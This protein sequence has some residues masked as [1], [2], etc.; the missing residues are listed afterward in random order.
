MKTKVNIK[1]LAFLLGGGILFAAGVHFL[2]GFQERRNA[3]ALLKQAERAESDGQND[4]AVKHL[5]TYLGFVPDD[6][7]VLARYGLLLERLA[8]SP[9]GRSQAFLVLEQVLR[10][11][12][13]RNDIRQKLIEIAMHPQV[14]R[15]SDAREHL[16]LLLR[17]LAGEDA[18]LEHR[19]AR[20]H[21]AAGDFPQAAQWY[22]KAIQ[23][24]PQQTEAYLQLAHVYR[25]RLDKA[26]RAD[27]VMDQLVAANA[28]SF[29]A[30]L[31]RGRYYL[32]LGQGEKA[33]ADIGR[34]AELAPD[35]AAVIL[36]AASM[37]FSKGDLATARSRLERG[38]KINPDK[39]EFY[40]ALS[41][42]E[43]KAKRPTEALS[44][45]RRGTEAIPADT[46][47]LWSLANLLIQQGKEPTEEL[48]RLAQRGVPDAQQDF[49]KARL[50]INQR[51][52]LQACRLLEKH[53]V[54][55]HRRPD[56]GKHSD[57][58]LGECYGQFGNLD[59]QYA[60]YR[61]AVS[62]DPL[63]EPACLGLASV[64]AAQGQIDD[65]LAT[66][67]RIMA[68]VPSARLA[69]A[70]LMIGQKARLPAERQRW[71]EVDQLLN[72]ETTPG[73]DPLELSVVRA[74]SLVVQGKFDHA[75]KLLQE[76]REAHPQET[77]PVTALAALAERRGKPE[78]ALAILDEAR[79]KL[80]DRLE[81]RLAQA[82]V[83]SKK[84][85][86]DARRP[87]AALGEE[88][89]RFSSEERARLL[90]G[91]ADAHA[92]LGDTATAEKL[93]ARVAE[94]MPGDLSCRVVLF[95][96]AL[97]NGND[98]AVQRLLQE[99]ERIEGS[100]GT[101][102]RFAKA[103]Y[104][105]RQARKGQ[106][107]NVEPAR[108]LLGKLA[109]ARPAWSRVPLAQAEI[110]DI[111]QDVSA[112]IKSYQ[113][114]LELGERN[115][116]ALR[117]LVELLYQQRRYAEADEVVQKLPEQD[118]AV[119][120]VQ[121]LAAEISL[122]RGD[123]E[124]ALK[125]AR[126]AVS[127]Q[128]RDY[129]DYLWLGQLLSATGT[130]AEAEP[131]L[132]RAVELGDKA[133]DTW[134]ALILH[135]A[136]SG[137][138]DKAEAALAD[139]GKKLVS[140]QSALVLAPCFEALGQI[141]QARK[142]YTEALATRPD[143]VAALRG[144][145]AFMLRHGPALAAQQIL[146]KLMALS[147]RA[148]EDAA[149]AKRT[150]AV[151]LSAS[152]NYAQW[153]EA[154]ALLDLR[155]DSERAKSKSDS[156]E[157]QRARAAVLA[158]NQSRKQ[159][160]RAIRILEDIKARQP[161]AAE[162]QFLLAQL[163][164]ALG[165]WPLARQEILDLLAAQP[166]DPRYPAH[167]AQSLLRRGETGEAEIWLAKLETL[168]GAAGTFALLDIQARALAARGK[169]EAALECVHGYEQ[170]KDPQG[171]D[172]AARLARVTALLDS[173][174][175]AY[176]SEKSYAYAA[177]VRY[178]KLLE[179]RPERTIDF[180][181]F[182]TRQGRYDEAL[183][184]CDKSW[185][186]R[187]PVD[188]AVASVA[189]LRAMPR[190]TEA[191]QQRVERAVTTAIDKNR[192]SAGALLVCLADLRDMQGRYAD[193]EKVYRQALEA[194]KNNV[195]ALNN[196]AYL[197]ALRKEQATEALELL[198]RAI[199]VAGPAPEL[200]D[201][202]ALVQLKQ[203]QPHRAIKDLE[204]ALAEAPLPS[205]CYHLAQAHK[206]AKNSSAARDAL[207]RAKNLGL[208]PE[209]LHTLERGGYQQLHAELEVR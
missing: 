95:D 5:R 53:Q 155:E 209:Q 180:V 97:H 68:R 42:L 48:A 78:A 30:L 185:V 18:D 51:Q 144:G 205:L 11:Q 129:R 59:Q 8:K 6:T 153:R 178:G 52:W 164:E 134:V 62:A 122:Q 57:L 32:E 46:D 4:Q 1:L 31:A 140:E 20:C 96:L 112:A 33:A 92:R 161:L 100:S 139:A 84:G 182:L 190:S 50:L 116:L 137:Q 29:P 196:L 58:L 17:N 76:A 183:D 176:A 149:W 120:G 189:V 162:E 66:Y 54:E 14:G 91:L 22:E 151:L 106:I 111:E 12:P 142:G 9:N 16:E 199:Q 93:W 179:R 152:G 174:S 90:A 36:A 141:D 208:R 65:A 21:E 56:L 197:L 87:L 40:L 125:L 28:D 177:E 110:S 133:P 191:Q 103:C 206:V 60:A 148:P 105:I 121:R 181:A 39:A 89:E 194:D 26:Q 83:W 173:L 135:L 203:G 108:A 146:R 204:E 158:A 94:Q 165:S 19:L 35:D 34:A 170:K 143:D 200:I 126:Q 64:Q 75:E 184:L 166:K 41:E 70:R 201:T 45:L 13:E 24:A 195:I 123:P 168:P 132:R 81:L 71:H 99:M 193:A 163:H 115:P 127:E 61:R 198:D 80:G 128:S 171:A 101:L 118:A 113:R 55:L 131:V 159:R 187:P 136:R 150:L 119:P 124:R 79:K 207:T 27:Q 88:A 72:D 172:P 86:D 104:W 145:A 44:C 117:R 10:R 23:H 186:N 15:Y 67:R 47:L 147:P 130:A 74:E 154:M 3:G 73:A 37:A 109:A 160:Q 102:W 175:Q 63:W 49:L 69:A 85:G 157:D 114:A 43:M 169:A 107:E 188:V 138:K 25:R 7:D 192:A 202:R 38:L 98:T 82:R 156:V 2:H 77:L 167:Y